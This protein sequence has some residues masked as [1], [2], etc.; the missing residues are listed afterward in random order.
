LFKHV[1]YIIQENRTYD[2]VLGDM[3]QGNGDPSLCVFGEQVSPNHHKTAR[4]F[5]LL[6][7][8]YCSGVLSADGHQWTDSAMANEYLERSFASFPR[9]YVHGMSDGGIDALAYSS[10]GF[11]WDNV[12]AHGKTLRDYG[13]FSI[14]QP[15]WKDKSKSGSPAFNDYYQDFLNHTGQIELSCRPAIESLRPYLV[16]NTVGWALNIPDVIKADRFINDLKA[17]EKTGDF[18]NLTII[19]LPNDHTTGTRQGFPTPAA[20][21]A[22]NDLAFGRILDALSH[23]RFWKETCVFAIED[24]PQAGWDH[25]SAYRTTCYVASPYTRRGAVVSTQYNQTSLLRTIELMLGLPPMNQFDATATPMSDCFTNVAN[26]TPFDVLPNSVPLDQMNPEPRKVSD[27]LLRKHALLSAR[28]PIAL[29][30]QCPEDTLNRII[31]HAV[32]GSA[33]PYPAWAVAHVEDDD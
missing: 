16:T 2:Q 5:V 15:R 7:N 20:Q 9:S 6:D 23:S 30:D 10:A 14:A 13:E 19:C 21:V 12:I 28:L 29:P 3:S 8:T 11:I 4:D 24:D 17:A 32:K 25:V 26:L 31:W 27:S 18:A 33:V 1:V 22:D